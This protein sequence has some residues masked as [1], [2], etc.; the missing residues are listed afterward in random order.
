[1]I[2]TVPGI[3]V[4]QLLTIATLLL[5]IDSAAGQSLPN[6]QKGSVYATNIKVDGTAAE[7]KEQFKAFNKAT[8]V[9]YTMANDADHLYLIVQC[10]YNDVIDK[11]LRGGVTLTI[12]QAQNPKYKTF[13]AVTF[14]ELGP[15]D[16]SLLTNMFARKVIDKRDAAGAD[17]E[18]EDL[19]KM[20]E[21]RAKLIKVLSDKDN[22]GVELSV[23]N[24]EGIKA[25]ARF[26]KRLA[27]TYELSVPLK[28]LGL[29]NGDG[30]FS[31]RVKINPPSDQVVAHG[32][33]PPSPPIAV[34]STAATDFTGE[35]TL[36]VK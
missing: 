32:S 31:Y 19:N 34:T 36:A 5:I 10:R 33:G 25:A 2:K 12:S 11:I 13:T 22:T 7:L 28:M 27:Y 16:E 15:S 20:F 35:Y 8:D 18:I 1:M 26:N 24:E 9:Y 23:Y 29:A 21:D 6:V 14:P 30:K 4:L 17:V 3:K